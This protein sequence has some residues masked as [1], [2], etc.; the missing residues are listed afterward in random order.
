[1]QISSLIVSFLLVSNKICQ[2]SPHAGVVGVAYI[3]RTHALQL[4]S[5]D[6]I[7]GHFLSVC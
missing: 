3:Y 2:I 6:D 5:P 1:M 4:E 7:G